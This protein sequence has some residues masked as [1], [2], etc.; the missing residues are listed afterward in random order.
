LLRFYNCNLISQEYIEK[1]YAAF[2]GYKFQPGF[3]E[4]C[5]P[6]TPPTDEQLAAL[7]KPL[8]QISEEEFDRYPGSAI[9]TWGDLEDYKYFFPR[10]TELVTLSPKP[11]VFEEF[12]FYK[13]D[14]LDFN[15]WP[16]TEK[17]VTCKAIEQYFIYRISNPE[18]YS[19]DHLEVIIGLIGAEK[20]IELWTNDKSAAS[21]QYIA[22]FVLSNPEYLTRKLAGSDAEQFKTWLKS[23][24]VV[25]KLILAAKKCDDDYHKFNLETAAEYI[26]N[27]R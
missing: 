4:R 21:A 3:R 20:V 19:I 1:L 22:D 11:A 8:R 27:T 16:E 26:L 9:Y 5:S 6:L 24:E 2:S 23:I 17:E 10:L 12:Y 18:G 13:F 7:R 15:N 25:N 14:S